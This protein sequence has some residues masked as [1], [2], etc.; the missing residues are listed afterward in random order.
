MISIDYIES[1]VNEIVDKL[2]KKFNVNYR[3]PIPVA[4]GSV[5]DPGW[6]L[7]KNLHSWHLHPKE[8]MWDCKSVIVFAIP[9][10]INAVESNLHG[11]L[12]SKEWLFEYCITNEVLEIT[13]SE[14]C[15]FLNKLDYKCVSVRPTHEF[16]ITY[17][18][19]RWSHRHV[20]YIVG[21]GTFG[22][23]NM[24]ITKMGCAVRISAVLTDASIEVSEKPKFEYCLSKRGRKCEICLN[25]CPINAFK[26]WNIGKY[27]C[28]TWLISIDRKF[29]RY[30]N[31]SVDA[32]GKC[33]VG[34]PCTYKIPD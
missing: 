20:G 15:N 24:L 21:L 19:S 11:L 7:L 29:R 12:P 6:N 28:Y 22:L 10:S 23:N 5:N 2:S 31:K 16:E 17:L 34:L 14:I 30:F 26:D 33:I 32:C 1:F 9:L 8:L 3:F 13:C 4:I 18:R 27:L 25:K